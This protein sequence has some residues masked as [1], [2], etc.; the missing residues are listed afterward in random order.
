MSV[1]GQQFASTAA[2]VATDVNDYV[3]GGRSA[4]RFDC[5]GLLIVSARALGV[6]LSGWSRSII[7]QCTPIS[8]EEA[9]RTPGAI[10]FRPGHIAVS[11][12][13]GR[14]AEARSRRSKPRSGVYADRGTPSDW[15]R[16]G[17][18]PGVDYGNARPAPTP[19][20]ATRPTLRFGVGPSGHT[21]D[22]A[23]ALNAW[24]GAQVLTGAGPFGPRTRA[25][26]KEFQ[27]A[28]GLAVDGIV[29]PLTWAALERYL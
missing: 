20:P 11:L 3:W 13:D 4:R 10:L 17:L 21:K 7:D 22:L 25:L 18:V 27:A 2:E 9:L 15:T 5:S 24:K 8:V 29:G 1:T 28:H 6:P 19:V 26:V 16:A 14:T 23:T 12:G